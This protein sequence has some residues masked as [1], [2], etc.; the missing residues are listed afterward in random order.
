MNTAILL[1]RLKRLRR[2]QGVYHPPEK[3]SDQ[4][5]LELEIP[6]APK[7]EPPLEEEPS[8]VIVIDI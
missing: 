2:E 5:F 6:R 3:A 4:P 1:E 8:R 7:E